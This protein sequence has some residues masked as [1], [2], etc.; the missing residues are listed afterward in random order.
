MCL[1]NTSGAER[2]TVDHAEHLVPLAVVLLLHDGEDD[3]KGEGTC[4]R[5]QLHE[6]IAVLRREEVGAHT[7]D[8][9]KL[10]KGGAEILEDGTQLYRGQTVHDFVTAQDGDHLTQTQGSVLVFCAL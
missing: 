3:G 4:P 2:G 6:L 7:H 10:D 8:L 9:P 5:L 1:S